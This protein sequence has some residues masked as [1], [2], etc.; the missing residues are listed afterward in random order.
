MDWSPSA[1]GPGERLVT[2]EH[3]RGRRSARGLCPPPADVIRDPFAAGCLNG[4]GYFDALPAGGS[5]RPAGCIFRQRSTC[6]RATKLCARRPG[7]R[8]GLLRECSGGFD[9]GG[10]CWT[11]LAR[12]RRALLSCGERD[13]LRGGQVASRAAFEVGVLAAVARRTRKAGRALLGC[14][15]V[16]LASGCFEVT[17]PGRISSL[18]QSRWSRPITQSAVP[19]QLPR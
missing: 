10:R 19:P 7:P 15:T 8:R 5:A 17:A 12:I 6:G 4:R 13:R 3:W 14:D 16:R 2:G 18:A 11:E 9:H 1:A